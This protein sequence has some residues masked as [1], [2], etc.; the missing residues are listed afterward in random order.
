MPTAVRVG[1]FDCVIRAR[2]AAAPQSQRCGHATP[3]RPEGVRQIHGETEINRVRWRPSVRVPAFFPRVDE[4]RAS[5]RRKSRSRLGPWSAVFSL[6]KA[7][8]FSQAR[9]PLD[10]EFT[11]RQRSG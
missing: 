2:M 6:E 8:V 3:N 10:G 4:N 1:M 9:E 7:A 5:I 11:F